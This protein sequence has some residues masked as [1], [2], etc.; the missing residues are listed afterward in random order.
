MI[1]IRRR[2]RPS[3]QVFLVYISII[4]F[5]A[6]LLILLTACGT[7]AATAPP[8]Q[9]PAQSSAPATPISVVITKTPEE[10]KL[11][12]EKLKDAMLFQN[13]AADALRGVDDN[14]KF[15]LQMAGFNDA[16]DEAQT[17]YDVCMDDE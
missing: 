15:L 11:M 4:L 13:K 5:G 9:P 10:C 14:D 8:A 16:M 6:I 1:A 17:L 2:R 7:T 12:V 3:D